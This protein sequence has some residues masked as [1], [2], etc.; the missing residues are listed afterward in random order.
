VFVDDREDVF[1]IVARIDY[2]RFARAL[3]SNDR[4][5]ALERA[6]GN[7]FVDH[8]RIELSEGS[9]QQFVLGGWPVQALLGRILTLPTIYDE[10]QAPH[11]IVIPSGG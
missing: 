3:I 2:Q 9:P 11:R 10:H 1:D 5:V 4:A 8:A 6:D 7:E